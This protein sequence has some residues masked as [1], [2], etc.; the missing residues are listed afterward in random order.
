MGNTI[1]C[2]GNAIQTF[3]HFS[4]F[5]QSDT[6]ENKWFHL[7]YLLIGIGS[8]C[9]CSRASLGGAVWAIL[10]AL[11]LLI[12]RILGRCTLARTC[13]AE[14]SLSIFVYLLCVCVWIRT[15]KG[16][17]NHSPVAVHCS[18]VERSTAAGWRVAAG[19]SPVDTGLAVDCTESYLEVEA[20][21]IYEVVLYHFY[22]WAHSDKLQLLENITKGQQL[23]P[24]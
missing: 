14:F 16:C 5:R 12:L 7:I 15:I 24:S 3:S 22:N 10:L 2:E 9:L 18:L 19:W 11:S 20:H 6:F 21:S 23:P 4:Y 13:S 17:S 8:L 1:H